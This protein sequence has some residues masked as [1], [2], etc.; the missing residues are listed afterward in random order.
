[1]DAMMYIQ[2]VAGFLIQTVPVAVLVWLPFEEHTKKGI[3]RTVF[4]ICLV[5]FAA[6]MIFGGLV[7]YAIYLDVRW[8]GYAVK[9]IYG[10]A[11]LYA[12]A[13]VYLRKVKEILSKKLL[14]LMIG[15][16]YEAIV[17]TIV[18]TI[19]MYYQQ[20][21]TVYEKPF[22]GR[23]VILYFLITLVTW[24][25]LAYFSKTK[26]KDAMRYMN[27][28]FLNRCSYYIAGAFIAYCIF[29]LVA[30][31][32]KYPSIWSPFTLL[33]CFIVN[34]III[35]VFFFREV[36][37]VQ[38]QI[39]YQKQ[40]EL[41]ELQYGNIE[42]NIRETR[43]LHHDI[44]HHMNVIHQLNQKGKTKEVGSY[45]EQYVN[46][47]AA[48]SEV[49]SGNILID[50]VLSYHVGRAKE[51][52]IQVKCRVAS[53]L[54]ENLDSLDM[55]VLLGNSLE[56]AIEACDSAGA[57]S[58]FIRISITTANEILL[59]LI[60]NSCHMDIEKEVEEF[61]GYEV[62]ESSKRE[63]RQGH[64][65]Q[66]ISS[67]AQKYGG[68]AKFRRTGGVFTTRIIMKVISE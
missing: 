30:S 5:L 19:N 25:M 32:Y 58:P 65:L 45:I 63:G 49:Y 54:E 34:D 8:L 11:A 68:I 26:I 44:R 56:N 35:L 2:Q 42:H 51:K 31:L 36:R 4:L 57:K 53:T 13:M 12:G 47:Y 20:V 3:K 39:Q 33:G 9:F 64:G 60:E 55:V 22:T 62:F 59:I 23:D 1:M 7:L 27:E 17:Y 46:K 14:V 21:I 43:R 50:S 29:A 40:M 66:S 52:G 6:S 15:I 18:S 24:P 48:E 28:K 41:M 61:T 67:I 38:K 37:S 10:L 16:H